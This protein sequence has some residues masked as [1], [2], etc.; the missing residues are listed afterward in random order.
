MGRD[1]GGAGCQKVRLGRCLGAEKDKHQIL[2]DLVIPPGGGTKAC[3]LR[4]SEELHCK[5]A[6][7]N[8]WGSGG[9]WWHA[10]GLMHQQEPGV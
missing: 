5:G 4:F 2:G 3:H 10:G 1:S 7:R 6:Q 8:N 9:R